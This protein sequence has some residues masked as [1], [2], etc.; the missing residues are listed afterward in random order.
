L[1]VLHITNWYPN[2]IDPVDA[3]FIK[4][5]IDALH[6]LASSSVM[7]IQVKEGSV[8]WLSGQMSEREKYWILVAPVNS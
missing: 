7:H 2:P 1:R 6:P 8:K 3:Q 4:D 5:Q